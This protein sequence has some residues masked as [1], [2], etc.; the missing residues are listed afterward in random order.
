MF[1]GVG[2]SDA[3]GVGGEG[4]LGGGTGAGLAEDVRRGAPAGI[5]GRRETDDVEADET[6]VARVMLVEADETEVEDKDDVI[7][8]ML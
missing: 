5:V 3:C 8:G 7:D 2:A 6:V 1:A 4:F